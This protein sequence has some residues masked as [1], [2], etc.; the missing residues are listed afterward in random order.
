MLSDRF[1]FHLYV[2]FQNEESFIGRELCDALLTLNKKLG[3]KNFKLTV[4]FS[5]T[6]D[7]AEK[8]RRWDKS[9][10][11]EELY[12]MRGTIQRVWVCGPP[13]MNQSFDQSL[14]DLQEKLKLRSNQIEIM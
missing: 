7:K 14:E 9:F 1:E 12:P 8:P 10:I 5:E 2:S 4:R 11:L 6:K 3:L 13:I